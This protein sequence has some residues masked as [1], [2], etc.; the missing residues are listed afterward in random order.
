[1]VESKS[2]KFKNFRKL[3]LQLEVYI[4]PVEMGRELKRCWLIFGVWQ[5][6]WL[7]KNK[8]LKTFKSTKK[9]IFLYTLDWGKNDKNFKT[10]LYLR[11]KSTFQPHPD[12]SHN[13]EYLL[14]NRQHFPCNPSLQTAS[15]NGNGLNSAKSNRMESSCK[16]WNKNSI[17]KARLCWM[18]TSSGFYPMPGKSSLSDRAMLFA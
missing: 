5:Y 18:K 4:K 14:P 13:F 11:F 7:K 8:K 2:L 15:H 9:S 6:I 10:L 3:K 1:M 17:N 16:R 12:Y